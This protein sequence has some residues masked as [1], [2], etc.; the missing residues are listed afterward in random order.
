MELRV[1]RGWS[2]EVLAE[3]A[4]LHRNYIGHIERG[5]VNVGVG[6]FELGPIKQ[7]DKMNSVLCANFLIFR[8]MRIVQ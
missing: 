5:E 8:L 3:V 4:G 2:Q 6:N 1:T 7:C